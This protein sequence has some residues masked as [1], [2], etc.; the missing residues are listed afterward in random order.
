MNPPEGEKIPLPISPDEWLKHAISDIKF[1]KLG[2]KEQDILSQQICFHARKTVEKAL[3]AILLF[4][5]IDFPL[6]HDIEELIELLTNS[7]ISV[8]EEILETDILTPYAVETRYPGYWGEITENDVDEALNLA[9]KVIE[10][11]KKYIS[12]GKI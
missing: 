7:G 11:V 4:C 6:T 1:A 3:K 2:K 10:W 9:E 8:P 12:E 5:K